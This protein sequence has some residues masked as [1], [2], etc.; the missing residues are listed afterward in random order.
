MM[1]RVS[2]KKQGDHRQHADQAELLADHGEQEVGVRLGQ[3]V[4]LLDA[5]A[6]AHAEDLA[7]ADGDQRVRRAGSPCPRRGPRR[8]GRGR[9]RC[10]RAAR[11]RTM[12]MQREGRP[13]ARRD[14]QNMRP[15]TPPRNRMPI[16][17]DRDHHEGAHVGLGQQQH[18]HQRPRASAIGSTAWMKLL[19][20]VH[21]AHHVVGGVQQHGQLGQLRG[22][23][24]HEAQRNP[25]P[26]AVHHL[27]H[28]R[29]QHRDQQQQRHHE[30]PRR[31][32]LPGAHRDRQRHAG[33]HERRARSTRTWRS[34]KCVG[35]SCANS[36]VVRQRDRGRIHHHQPP[37]S[38]SPTIDPDQRLVEAP[39]QRVGVARRTSVVQSAHRHR[40]PR[41]P[42]GA[43]TRPPSESA[44]RRR[45]MHPSSPRSCA[46]AC[47]VV[48]EDLG[49]VRVVAEHVQAGAGRA[50]AARHRPRCAC[51]EAPAHGRLQRVAALQRHAASSAS[52]RAI[53]AASRPISATARAWRATGAASG[54]KSWPLP[55]PPRISDQPAGAG[56]RPS[57]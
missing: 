12:I 14:Q 1:R 20:H 4:Q 16:A 10:A 19:L 48:D 40:R 27:A 3:P 49:A 46:S 53:A 30:Q 29:D 45:C 38:I 39:I 22:L 43:A 44:W 6:Q 36:R 57:R 50:T 35:R 41:L 34:T 26:R 28:A 8:R 32:L 18:A 51:C 31:Q 56:R 21:L 54:A 52:A 2:Q 37:A 55:S 5:A 47:T 33:R 11:A 24:V 15:L 23:E 42:A 13:P 9:R 17:I 7:A 25:A